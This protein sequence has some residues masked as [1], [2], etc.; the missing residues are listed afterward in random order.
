K[1]MKIIYKLFFAG[2]I[3]LGIASCSDD[4]LDNKQY[5]TTPQEISSVEDLYSLMYGALIEARDVTYYG[6]D[7]I[8]YGALRGNDAFNDAGSGRFRSISYYNMTKSDAYA[9]DTYAQIYKVIA[10]L[11]VIIN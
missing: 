7:F 10:Q 6:R 2:M 5:S 4:F 11:N 8:V 9:T 1:I 3:T